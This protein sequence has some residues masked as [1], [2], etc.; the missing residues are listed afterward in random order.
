MGADF[1]AQNAGI[2]DS[3]KGVTAKAKLKAWT[4]KVAKLAEEKGLKHVRISQHPE[5]KNVYVFE[6][7]KTKPASEGDPQFDLSAPVAKRHA[8]LAKDE[9]AA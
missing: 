4:D 2:E 8:P 1:R 5:R 6:A 7:W 3:P 9:P